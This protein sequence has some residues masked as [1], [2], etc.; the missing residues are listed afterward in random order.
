M[1]LYDGSQ[2]EVSVWNSDGSLQWQATFVGEVSTIEGLAND[3]KFAIGLDGRVALYD[4]YGGFGVEVPVIGRIVAAINSKQVIVENKGLSVVSL[5]GAESKKSIESGDVEFIKYQDGVLVFRQGDD[6]KMCEVTDKVGTVKSLAKYK[7]KASIQIK[8]K[9]LAVTFNDI[10]EETVYNIDGKAINEPFG[11]IT[12]LSISDAEILSLVND[13]KYLVQ[14]TNGDLALVAQDLSK[15]WIREALDIKSNGI[16]IDLPE[17][18]FSLSEEEL[19][20]EESAD[21]VSAYLRRI[22]RHIDDLRYLSD[23]IQSY[24]TERDNS[25]IFGFNKLFIIASANSLVAMDTANQGQTAWRL[26]LGNFEIF[27]IASLGGK[28]EVYI[29]GVDG[30]VVEVDGRVGKVVNEWT[31]ELNGEG[32]HEIVKIPQDEVVVELYVWTGADR[33]IPVVGA[34]TE[35]ELY[36]TK[37]QGT[38]ITGYLKAPNTNLLKQTW[39]FKADG[40]IVAAAKKS[41]KDVSVSIGTVLG[42][43]QV[44]YKYLHPNAVAVASVNEGGL[45]VY[46]VDTVSGRILHSKRHAEVGVRNVHLVYGEHWIVYSYFSN[47]PFSSEKIVVWDLFESLTPNEQT[48][49]Q[50]ESYSSFEAYAA[51][52]VKAQSF[53]IPQNSEIAAMSITVTEFGITSRAVLVSLANGQIIMIPKRVLDSRRPANRPLTKSE[54]EERLM[55]YDSYLGNILDPSRFVVSHGRTVWGITD[56]I[57][58]PT[59]LEST[60]LVAAYGKDVFFTRL[61]PSQPFDILNETSFSKNKLIATVVALIVMVIV[62]RPVVQNKLLNQ[63]WKI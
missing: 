21:I 17:I 61:T 14:Y 38:S 31:L 40:Q 63:K 19:L 28:S 50:N 23:Y 53:F 5:E 33:L 25:G 26:E 12:S 18:D 49:S 60:T 44:L 22:N 24:F 9:Q 42:D 20:F 3:G 2:S 35:E 62:M 46:L 10:Q 16:F 6:V 29:V 27:E 48:N 45:S 52:I 54:E 41:F 7:G 13:D 4:G 43:R 34:D 57:T 47:L 36:L 56:I 30:K 58:A 55:P 51:P 11:G 1:S 8:D 32:I 39:T 37:V 15:A 59:R